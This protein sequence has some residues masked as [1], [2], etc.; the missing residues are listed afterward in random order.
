MVHPLTAGSSTHQPPVIE[1]EPWLQA[2]RRV[3]VRL[4]VDRVRRRERLFEARP[5]S[6]SGLWNHSRASYTA[7]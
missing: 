4:L 3:R 5:R 6:L 2:D 1:R 7:L